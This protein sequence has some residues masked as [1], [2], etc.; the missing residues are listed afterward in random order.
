MYTLVVFIAAVLFAVAEG[1]VIRK[2]FPIPPEGISMEIT[3]KTNSEVSTSISSM[4]INVL[5]GKV[6]VTHNDNMQRHEPPILE[7]R[8]FVEP[9]PCPIGYFKRFRICFPKNEDDIDLEY[10]EEFEQNEVK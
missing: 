5:K 1:G 3:L 4:N 7:D 6:T 8:V 2:E 9:G 10:S